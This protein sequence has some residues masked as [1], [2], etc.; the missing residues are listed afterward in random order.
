MYNGGRETALRTC[1]SIINATLGTIADQLLTISSKSVLT[2][3]SL[4]SPQTVPTR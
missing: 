3:N 2:V 4:T 1:L